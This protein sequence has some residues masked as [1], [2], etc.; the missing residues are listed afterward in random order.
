MKLTNITYT[1][2]VILIGSL[3]VQIRQ[4]NGATRNCLI[5]LLHRIEDIRD[6][7]IPVN[8]PKNERNS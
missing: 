3:R 6:S 4:T 8:K 5:N 1:E 2:Q 7:D